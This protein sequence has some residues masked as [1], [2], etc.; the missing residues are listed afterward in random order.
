MGQSF[1]FNLK[2]SAKNFV[3]ELNNLNI[4]QKD[5]VVINKIK[6]AVNDNVNKENEQYRWMNKFLV[7][8]YTDYYMIKLVYFKILSGSF[9]SSL[10]DVLKKLIEEK[11]FYMGKYFKLKYN[12]CH[13]LLLDNKNLVIMNDYY[14]NSD[15]EFS[16]SNN[17]LIVYNSKDINISSKYD[18]LDKVFSDKYSNKNTLDEVCKDIIVNNLTS[19]VF[20]G[21]SFNKVI[22]FMWIVG[23]NNVEGSFLQIT[24]YYYYYF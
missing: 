19:K 3:E 21:K 12:K 2:K 22:Y 6:D 4:E 10:N 14:L 15:Y 9:I 13:V 23:N 24:H 8:Y 16:T 17:E 1:G 20:E 18:S 11:K 5:N 7:Y